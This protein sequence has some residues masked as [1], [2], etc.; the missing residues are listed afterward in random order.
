MV[1]RGNLVVGRKLDRGRNLGRGRKRVRAWVVWTPRRAC[2][3]VVVC[4][5]VLRCCGVRCVVWPARCACAPCVCRAW[6][7]CAFLLLP[8]TSH[9]AV[10]HHCTP[11]PHSYTNGHLH[12]QHRRRCAGRPR[13][14]A[15]LCPLQP[16]SHLTAGPHSLVWK[17]TTTSDE[18]IGGACHTGMA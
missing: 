6:C 15:Q 3:T 5:V 18:A 14:T 8:I 10:A 11:L 1:W 13:R 2:R 16:Y 17:E 7:A 12:N 4:F 9:R